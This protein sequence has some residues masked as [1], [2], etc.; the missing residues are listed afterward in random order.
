MRGETPQANI[1]PVGQ[2]LKNGGLHSICA[3][4]KESVKSMSKAGGDSM[5]YNRG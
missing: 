4:S 2:D 3:E 1:R 5:N